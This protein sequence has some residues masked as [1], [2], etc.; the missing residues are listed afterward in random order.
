MK[1]NSIVEGERELF[2]HAALQLLDEREDIAISLGYC[3]ISQTSLRSDVLRFGKLKK[4]VRRGS[5][6]NATTVWKAKLAEVKYG[7]FI[8]EDDTAGINPHKSQ[9]S[10]K[11]INLSNDSCRCKVLKSSSATD[12]LFEIAIFGGTRRVFH[13]SSAG[14]RDAWVRAI[15]AAMICDF[16]F[17]NNRPRAEKQ[18]PSFS[19]FSP[20]KYSATS[21]ES[22]RSGKSTPTI[23]RSD[24][25]VDKK[26]PP[27]S[28]LV[29]SL[30][31]MVSSLAQAR[32]SA[33]PGPAM[34][35]APGIARFCRLQNQLASTYSPEYYKAA[36]DNI[37]NNESDE[38]QI[39]VYFV[40]VQ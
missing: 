12:Y 35:H 5:I 37:I 26:P 25:T 9:E 39:P 2:L 22:S 11:V 31:S 16:S 15:N 20:F 3:P 24:S 14:D 33:L 40:K 27:P 6:A 8:Y 21:K 13:A 1:F 32:V 7:S 28:P 18:R 19:E 23:S 38:I 30:Q 17:Y 36:L 10:R 4:A 34:N 29:H